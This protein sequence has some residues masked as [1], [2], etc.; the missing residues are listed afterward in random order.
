M[1]EF[2]RR[3]I[4]DAARRIFAEQGLEGASVRT[5]A[6]AAGC[7]TG[8][9]YPLFG[10]KEEI[11]AALL[12]E[13]LDDLY[14]HVDAV[15]RTAGSDRDVV[16]GAGTAFYDYYA[17]RPF[18]VALGLY[19]WRGGVRP[20]GL[21]RELDAALNVKLTAV[22]TLIE[23]PLRRCSGWNRD[24]ARAETTA[25]FAFAIG[26]LILQHTGRQKMLR[27]APEALVERY[28]AA[29]LDRVPRP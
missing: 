8:A 16:V 6:A 12:G 4:L 19:L 20:R 28:L 22:L 26:N 14:A 13:S 24:E 10:A 25:L 11:Y 29:L 15:C 2:R 5:I 9:I 18:E 17:V 3:L 7:T 1:R 27:Q 23:E 21:T